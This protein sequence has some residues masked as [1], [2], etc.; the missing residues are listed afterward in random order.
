MNLEIGFSQRI[1][2]QWLEH[3]ANLM[4]TNTPKQEI[5]QSLQ[6]LL[7]DK[8]SVGGNA[9][10]GNRDKAITILMKIWVRVR[11][12]L[13][14]LRDDGLSL[15][16][17][18]PQD[19]HIAVHWGMCMAVY[20]FFEQAASQ[21]G[22]LLRLQESAAISQVQRRIQEK[23][24]QRETVIQ[25]L[26]RIIRVFRDWGVIQNGS[27]KGMYD[28]GKTHALEDPE[29]IQWL[30]E[31]TL[32]SS[33]NTTASLKELLQKPSLFPFNITPVASH[34]FNQSPRLEIMQ[35]SLDQELVMLQ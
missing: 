34:Q 29:L 6:E 19:Q 4:M 3:T 26:R 15:L 17:R 35:H 18:L 1:Q 11:D 20:P 8:I 28:I 33:G 10:R 24:G 30:V 16:Q 5:K 12:P 2:F 22:R 23:Y 14:P 9:K 13:I 25:A 31:A 7:L 32:I 27:Q 21:V